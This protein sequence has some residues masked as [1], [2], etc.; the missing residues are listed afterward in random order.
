MPDNNN[1]KVLVAMSGGV[2]SS[3]TAVLMKEQG[4]EV[5]GANMRLYD[6]ETNDEGCKSCCSFRDSLDASSVCHRLDVGF[7]VLDMREAFKSDVIGR[8]ID[9]YEKGDT[10]NPCID[11]NRYMKFGRMW[12]FAKSIGCSYMATGHYARI[13]ADEQ[14]RPVLKKALNAAKDQS[15]VLYTLPRDMLKVMRFPLGSIETKEET[16]KI[17]GQAGLTNSRKRES[18]DI[19]FV[20]DGDY[21]AFIE[22]NSGLEHPRGDFVDTDGNVMGSHRGLIHYT[23][24]QRKG[25]GISALPEPY[26]VKDKDTENNKVILSTNDELFEKELTAYDVNWLVWDELPGGFRCSAKIRYRHK[27]QPC[28]VYFAPDQKEQ[29]PQ[30]TDGNGMSQRIRV[31]F[32]EPQRAITPGQAVVLYD[33]DTV[34]G[35]GTI[36]K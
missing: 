23:I 20:P 11:C 12:E 9:A 14:G 18:Q 10:P 4:Y 25:L 15:Y 16:R 33:G 7:E 30:E 2:D 29:N 34:L 24:G 21:A 13:E 28:R 26:Y 17:A 8:F 19:C 27:E 35:G 32:D 22:E 36:K 6:P 31:V 5:V 3:A 1:K